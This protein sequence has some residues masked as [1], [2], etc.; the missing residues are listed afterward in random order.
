VCRIIDTT[1][2]IES[3]HSRVR[4]TA[5]SHGHFPSDKAT[6]KL[7][8]LVLQNIE[9]KWTRP[10]I[11]WHQAKAQFAIHFEERFLVTD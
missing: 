6:S 9:T 11:A 1:N 7:I 4:K 3:L 2:A 8:Y 5:R 10:P